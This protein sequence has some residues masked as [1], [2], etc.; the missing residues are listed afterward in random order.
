[1]KFLPSYCIAI[2]TVSLSW[3]NSALFDLTN[4]RYLIHCPC[5]PEIELTVPTL[6]SCIL[7]KLYF[8]LTL[9]FSFPPPLVITVGRIACKLY[10]TMKIDAA[11]L[12]IQTNWRGQ[13]ARIAFIRVKFAVI[14]LQTGLRAMA[15]R[16]EFKYRKQTKA[17]IIIQVIVSLL[18]GFKDI[19]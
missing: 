4:L 11:T 1:M 9:F 3:D 8:S 2:Y 5:T 16:K 7:F 18:Y 10:E 15:A 14:N 6:S 12:R 19:G 17:A 13:W